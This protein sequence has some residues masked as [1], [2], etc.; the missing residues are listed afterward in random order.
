MK[1]IKPE[2]LKE[3]PFTLIGKDW[4]LITAEKESKVNMMTASWGNL[5]IM[6]GKNAA[7][8]YIRES[9]YTKDFVDNGDHF[10]LC[11]L[12]EEMRDKLNYCGSASGRNEDKVSKSGLTVEHAGK[13]PYFAESRLVLVCR[14]LY[15]QKLNAESF[16]PD[17]KGIIDACYANGDWHTMYIAEVEQVLVKD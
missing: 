17:A 9:R 2:E 14:K 13:V 10:S 11:V 12:P 7:T 16:V 15:A 1:E 8:I 5:G 6:W 4:M 3:N